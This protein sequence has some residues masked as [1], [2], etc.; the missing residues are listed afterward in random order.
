MFLFAIATGG[1]ASEELPGP[2]Q[3]KVVS[4]PPF[5]G[6][7]LPKIDHGYILFARWIIVDGLQHD[8][9]YLKSLADGTEHR[10]SFWLHGA[11]I[12]W[13]NDLTIT[14]DGE[15]FVVGSFSRL[16][17]GTPINFMAQLDRTGS[18]HATIDM[19]TYEPELA[20]VTSDRSVWT[21]GQDWSAE[22]SDISY[23]L[24]R[25]YSST[26]RLLG[27]YL[28]SDSLPP[29]R[30]NFSTRLH[31]LGGS[32]GRVFLQCGDESVGAYIEAARTWAEIDLANRTAQMWQIS[33]PSF[34]YVTGFALLGKHQVYC[35]FKGRNT[36]FVRG[37][38]KLNLGQ[39]KVATW[40]P[41]P[42][43]VEY[44]NVNHESPPV[45]SVIG[46]DGRSLVYQKIDSERHTFFW[47]RP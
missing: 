6:H 4:I 43:M 30:L 17:D 45:M 33:H 37:F 38:F 24:L 31:R 20:C 18:T 35:S 22:R 27:S 36:V 42:G 32:P 21:L 47:V 9:L 23:Q 11:S 14:S 10:L 44:V 46:A 25:N 12:I 34:G 3:Q 8:A 2:W 15:L 16:R 40:D 26:G 19:G 41:I 28:P 29:V 1:S 5:P 39:P 13:V 7:T